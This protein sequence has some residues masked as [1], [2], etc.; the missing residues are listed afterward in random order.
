MKKITKEIL[1]I[2]VVIL[3]LLFCL[4]PILWTFI[5]SISPEN[6]ILKE[7]GGFLPDKIQLDNYIQVLDIN[8]KVGKIFYNGLFNSMKSAL[9]TIC[10]GLPICIAGAFSLS[11]YEYKYRKTI[12]NILL[13][14]IVIPV[15]ATVIPIYKIFADFNLLDN[16][17]WICIIYVS[18]FLPITTWIIK[19]YFS[20]IP[21][22]ILDAANIDGCDDLNILSKIVIPLSYPIIIA[23]VLVIFIMSWNQFQIP[24]ILSATNST[25]PLS[26]VMSEFSSKDSILY[27]LMA[28][29]GMLAIL[30][31]AI[32]AVMFRKY[33]VSGMMQGAVK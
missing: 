21:E 19:N 16:I 9:L 23:I 14:T 31:P 32:L 5:I 10:I 12:E 1:Y 18:S 22:E 13:S 7:V 4:G 27:G 25:K 17:F 20:N 29:T 28:S 26:V 2:F 3:F 15:F 11:F 8:T 24:L 33:L 30:P 6:E